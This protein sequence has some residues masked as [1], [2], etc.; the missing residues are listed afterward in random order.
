MA[1]IALVIGL[2]GVAAAHAGLV[3]SDPANGSEVRV[4]P[5]S[6]ILRF[7]EEVPV[8]LARVS[9][10]EASSPD[11]PDG[12]GGL[13]VAAAGAT[14][15]RAMLTGRETG[16]V[17]LSYR[18]TSAD[19]HPI[20]GEVTF[21]VSEPAGRSPGE[22]TRPVERDP[23]APRDRVA[24]PDRSASTPQDAADDAPTGTPWLIAVGAVLVLAV[25]VAVATLLRRASGG[26]RR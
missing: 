3:S 9:L 14:G 1:A 2:P 8:D 6:V 11:S 24:E 5:G 19:G 25:P 23:S 16:T 17:R 7:N 22:P 12:P 20:A 26:S 18:V 15:V 4:N 13:P 10:L 21:T